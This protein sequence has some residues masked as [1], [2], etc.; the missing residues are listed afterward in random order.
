MMEDDSDDLTDDEVLAAKVTETQEQFV[1]LVQKF[2][3]TPG[4][5][6]RR[7]ALRRRNGHLY[8]RVTC[9]TIDLTE[10]VLVLQVDWLKGLL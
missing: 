2:V 9:L 5:V 1:N 7:F 3:S 8:S 4:S 10:H 6:T